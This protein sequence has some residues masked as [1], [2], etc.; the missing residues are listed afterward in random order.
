MR[1]LPS[2]VQERLSKKLGTAFGG[3]TEAVAQELTNEVLEVIADWIEV[4]RN[5]APATGKE[6]AKAIRWDDPLESV[7]EQSV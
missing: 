4:Q 7:D 3:L 6:F 2:L 1:S 5:D